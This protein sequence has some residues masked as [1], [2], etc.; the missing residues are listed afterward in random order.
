MAFDAEYSFESTAISVLLTLCWTILQRIISIQNPCT[1]VVKIIAFGIQRLIRLI[2]YEW[3]EIEQTRSSQE[4]FYLFYPHLQYKNWFHKK[5]V[6]I[7][8]F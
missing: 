7:P 1:K 4:F 5:N 2:N 6:L 8:W 3:T